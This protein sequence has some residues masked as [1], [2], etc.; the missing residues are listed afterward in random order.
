MIKRVYRINSFTQIDHTKAENAQ[1][2][3]GG[4]LIQCLGVLYVSVKIVCITYKKKI[5]FIKS[6]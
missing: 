1:C 2:M 3:R 6:Y 4:K 5:R